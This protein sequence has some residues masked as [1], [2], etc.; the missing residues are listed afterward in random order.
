M[1]KIIPKNL[2]PLYL[3]IIAALAVAIIGLIALAVNVAG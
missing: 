1:K 2:W 3:A